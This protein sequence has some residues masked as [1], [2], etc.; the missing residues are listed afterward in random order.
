MNSLRVLSETECIYTPWGALQ[1]G[2]GGPWSSENFG[3][4]GH[5]AFGPTNNWPVCSLILHCRQLILRKISK[6]GASRCKILTLKCTKFT[7][8][9]GSAPDPAG[10][11]YSAPYPGLY[12]RG[13]LLRRWRET[14][15]GEE[16]VKG[17]KGRGGGMDLTHP[18]IL[19]WRPLMIHAHIHR[20]C[21][22]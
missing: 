16:K 4:V 10:G 21:G 19:V 6:I 15:E 8:C 14:G 17:R 12:L 22:L 5:N 1:R 2:P 13:L 18:K 3:W 20:R 11:A 9:W 7:F